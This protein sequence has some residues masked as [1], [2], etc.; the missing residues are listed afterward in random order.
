M[1]GD[2]AAGGHA[3][4]T[5]AGAGGAAGAAA[6]PGDAGDE[7][8]GDGHDG[9]TVADGASDQG[10]DGSPDLADA[11]QSP[12]ASSAADAM[13]AGAAL[14]DPPP[15][16]P[17]ASFATSTEE[18][19]FDQYHDTIWVNLGDPAS[20]Y[21][22]TPT[23]AFDSTLG[24]PAPGSLRVEVPFAGTSTGSPLFVPEYVTLRPAQFRTPATAVDW[25]GGTLH[26]RIRVDGDAFDGTAQLFVRTGSTYAYGGKSTRV[27]R[28]GE[29]QELSY[30]LA[31]PQPP[32]YPSYD[33]HQVL[34]FGVMLYTASS[35]Q[36]PVTLHIDSFTIDGA[37]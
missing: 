2:A 7:D 27:N 5:D 1:M 11:I 17:V 33:P 9:T 29:W 22:P 3:G 31:E 8:S 16:I 4:S 30:V 19:V 10:N 36:G 12:D 37:P 13:D 15:G 32:V 25:S 21:T 18:F 20:G 35:T 28:S 26:A 24:S 14:R 34:D 6:A 23:L